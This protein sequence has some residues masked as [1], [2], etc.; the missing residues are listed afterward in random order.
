MSDEQ[1]DVE[2][3]PEEGRPEEKAGDIAEEKASAENSPAVSAPADEAQRRPLTF[4][5]DLKKEYKTPK[6]GNVVLRVAILGALVVLVAVVVMLVQRWAP[7]PAE[8][9][10]ATVPI[11]ENS[12]ESIDYVTVH[13]RGDEPYDV[14]QIADAATTQYGVVGMDEGIKIQQYKVSDAFS[15]ATTLTGESVVEEDAQNLSQYGFDDPMST[16]T[17]H[18]NDGTEQVLILGGKLPS[19]VGWYL[20]KGD[21]STVYRV[22][23][24]NGSRMTHTLKDLRDLSLFDTITVDNADY[25]LIER[26]D[27]DTLEMRKEA[28]A[29]SINTWKILKPAEME[30]STDAVYEVATEMAAVALNSYV[31]TPEDYAPYGLEE[32][33]AT[34]MVKDSDGNR[35]YFRIGGYVPDDNTL[36]YIRLDGEDEVYTVKTDLLG[37]LNTATLTRVV[38]RFAAI[39]NI[40]NV[41][42]ADFIYQGSAHALT[43]TREEQFDENGD[44][45]TLANGQPNYLEEFFID[46]VRVDESAF[47]KIYQTMISVQVRGEL[48]GEVSGE[49]VAKITYTFNNGSEPATTE[50]I[51]YMQDFYAM[52]QNGIELFY[53]T[54]DIVDSLEAYM[55]LTMAL[56]KT[57]E[58]EEVDSI[59]IRYADGETKAFARTADG[60]TYRGEEITQERFADAIKRM[61]GTSLQEAVQGGGDA[62]PALTITYRYNDGRDPVTVEYRDSAQSMYIVGVQGYDFYFTLNQRTLL[63]EIEY[64][65][66]WVAS[67]TE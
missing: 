19:G 2:R 62:D 45:M 11:T 33:A 55:E 46:G 14:Q 66:T 30:A 54:R 22:S 25:M 63:S 50:F 43:I 10:D 42:R 48:T 49:P 29:V 24:Y 15:I 47:K 3:T 34:C 58:V 28:S 18:L 44:L 38:D 12:R 53:T 61:A 51:P 6:K 8:S 65:D 31:D 27:G 17:I 60:V 67:G 57:F 20:R 23:D 5:Q 52:S 37:F 4:E 35:M 7:P 32:P 16:F 64:F 9:V 39:V 1:K 59:E 41:D 36:R 26:A 56:P 21:G 40:S 13:I